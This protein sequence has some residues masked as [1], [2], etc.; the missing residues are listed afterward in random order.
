MIWVEK[1]LGELKTE[2]GVDDDHLLV[3]NCVKSLWEFGKIQT[4]NFP[5]VALSSFAA[6]AQNEFQ[7]PTIHEIVH[8]ETLQ[9]FTQS[10]IVLSRHPIRFRNHSFVLK[11]NKLNYHLDFLLKRFRILT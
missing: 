3:K 11:W 9:Q 4:E 6:K 1:M 2:S 8:K 7:H 5:S 10:G